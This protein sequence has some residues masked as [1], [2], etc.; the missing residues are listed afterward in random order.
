MDQ[1]LWEEPIRLLPVETQPTQAVLA[2]TCMGVFFIRSV[3]YFSQCFSFHNRLGPPV[4][5]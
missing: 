4:F 3:T 5:R 1:K 2:Q